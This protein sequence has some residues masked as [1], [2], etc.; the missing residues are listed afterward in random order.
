MVDEELKKKNIAYCQYKT[1]KHLRKTRGK[2]SKKTGSKS[3][4][5]IVREAEG[6][7]E[8]LWVDDVE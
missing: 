7:R 6:A 8:E 4:K 1:Q 2:S 5:E 3:I